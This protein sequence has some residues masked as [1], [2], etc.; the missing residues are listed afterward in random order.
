M[1]KMNQE[2]FEKACYEAYQLDWMISHGYSLNDLKEIITELA[3]QTIDDEPESA[4][5]SGRSLVNLV[6]CACEEFEMDAGFDGSLF[7]CKE[8]FLGAEYR[9]RGYMKHL[10]GMMPEPDKKYALW[11]EYTG[12]EPPVGL[13]IDLVLTLS[14]AHIDKETSKELDREG[15]DTY[16][17]VV[18]PKGKYGWWIYIPEKWEDFRGEMP[19]DEYLK[20]LPEG[21]A[22]CI[23]L[24]LE[25]N[26][27][28]LCIDQGAD[29]AGLPE[30]DW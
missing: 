21:L 26:C 5:A 7:A 28:W 30:Y 23:N 24:A 13:E 19:W 3:G 4:P 17:L 1:A 11:L 15:S 8:E 29:T 27:R 9:D 14:T 6:E 2:E 25:N 22:N 20:T 10:T 12:Q 18:Y 16:G